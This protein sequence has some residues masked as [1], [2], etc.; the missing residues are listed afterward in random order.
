MVIMVGDIENGDGRDSDNGS[1]YGESDGGHVT[2]VR[3][4]GF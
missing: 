2:S 4:S 1:C 3:A